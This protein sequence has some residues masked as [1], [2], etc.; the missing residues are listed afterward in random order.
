MNKENRI[1]EILLELIL[2]NDLEVKKLSEINNSTILTDD[3]GLDSFNLA[4]LTVLIEAEF[5]VDIF[6]NKMIRTY[7]EII[8]ELE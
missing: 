1:K 8:N 7:G 3:L 2:E 6:E 4:Q 5:N